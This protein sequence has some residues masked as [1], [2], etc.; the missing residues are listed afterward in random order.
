MDGARGMLLQVLL[1]KIVF[2]GTWKSTEL[3]Y[4]VI[5]QRTKIV[6]FMSEKLTSLDVPSIRLG[7][8][9][10]ESKSLGF[11]SLSADPRCTSAWEFTVALKS[12]LFNGEKSSLTSVR[13]LA[14]DFVAE[15]HRMDNS[16]G[17]R[18]PGQQH[19]DI[20]NTNTNWRP[21]RT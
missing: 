2:S 10:V 11:L 4:K 1:I 14:L 9:K 19:N 6:A 18:T 16:D 3:N 15:P 5:R 17:S 7:W 8:S 12:Q 20:R 13:K 21:N